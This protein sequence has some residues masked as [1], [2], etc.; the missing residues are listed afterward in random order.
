MEVTCPSCGA[1]NYDSARYC[2]KC[3]LQLG[4]A[5]FHE[6]PTRSFEEQRRVE[7]VVEHVEPVQGRGFDTFGSRPLAGEAARYVPPPSAPQGALQPGTSHTPGRIDTAPMFTGPVKKGPNV[8]LIIGVIVLA[9]FVG[10]GVLSAIIGHAIK[11]AKDAARAK[12]ASSAP[13]V[14]GKGKSAT[15]R[16][17]SVDPDTLPKELQGWYYD[18]ARINIFKLNGSSGFLIM[19]TD[20]DAGEVADFYREKFTKINTEIHEEKSVIIGGDAGQR[21][22]VIINEPDPGDDEDQTNI[23]VTLGNEMSFPGMPD[24][25]IPFGPGDVPKAAPPPPPAAPTPPSGVPGGVQEASKPAP[26]AAPA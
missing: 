21:A 13:A 15:G 11:A 17:G 4:S 5:E 22:T 14:P 7:P 6:A 9:L 24:I 2:R 26:P 10:A 16:G 3:G 1:E 8:F 23:V 18:G 19:K 25:N 12:E 20:D